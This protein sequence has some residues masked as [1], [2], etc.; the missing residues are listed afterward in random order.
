MTPQGGLGPERFTI[1]QMVQDG[2]ITPDEGAR[3]LEAMDRSERT[4]PAPP[5][6]P[7]VA[8]RNVRIR[9]TNK[10]GENDI[11][12]VLPFGLVDA[13]L[14]IAHKIAPGKI[15][16]ISEIRRSVQQ[17]YTGRLFNVDNGNDHIEISIEDK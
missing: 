1:L 9:V 14:N 8:A 17:G 12:L 16:D 11:D 6:P 7:P 5:P 4:A 10:R 3:L 15:P 2:T 13:G